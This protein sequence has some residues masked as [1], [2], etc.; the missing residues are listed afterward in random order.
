MTQSL[1]LDASECTTLIFHFEWQISL[2]VISGFFFLADDIYMLFLLLLLLLFWS[3][4]EQSSR[5][6]H[7]W[8]TFSIS[9]VNAV[10]ALKW[11]PEPA[12]A[13]NVSLVSPMWGVLERGVITSLY[14][15]DSSPLSWHSPWW[16][17][18]INTGISGWEGLSLGNTPLDLGALS[19]SDPFD[20]FDRK[21][22]IKSSDQPEQIRVMKT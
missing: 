8:L 10:C 11:L 14:S 1:S 5:G 3:D 7:F 15:T 20:P 18:T 21:D 9:W 6:W 12:E 19:V 4:W 17:S 16:D 22:V 2:P 13:G